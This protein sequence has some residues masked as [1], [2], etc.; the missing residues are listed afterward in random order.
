MCCISKSSFLASVH[1]GDVVVL[2]MCHGK[3]GR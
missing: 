2:G 3:R 1:V